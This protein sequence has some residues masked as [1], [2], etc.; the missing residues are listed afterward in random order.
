MIQTELFEAL[1]L[2][3]AAR[4]DQQQCQKWEQ[5]RKCAFRLFVGLLI[6]G[7]LA[8]LAVAVRVGPRVRRTAATATLSGL[9]HEGHGD[10]EHSKDQH[11]VDGATHSAPP[12]RPSHG[13]VFEPM[14]D[15]GN[16]YASAADELARLHRPKKLLLAPSQP[17]HPEASCHEC[18]NDSEQ[19]R[20]ELETLLGGNQYP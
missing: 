9:R 2:L 17:A 18:D 12:S 13:T 11:E 3:L 15:M 4:G 14:L 8:A 6:V 19:G 5:S 1:T 16:V 7:E 10:D 20:G